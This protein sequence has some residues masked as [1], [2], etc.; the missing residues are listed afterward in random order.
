MRPGRFDRVSD[1]GQCVPRKR[2]LLRSFNSGPEKNAAAF[3]A[4]SQC[5]RLIELARE[6]EPAMMKTIAVLGVVGTIFA[7][8]ATPTLA[9]TTHHDGAYGAYGQVV[10]PRAMRGPLMRAP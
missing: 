1:C 10:T 4:L 8:T 5:T 2:G 9:R 7:A 3:G 6:K